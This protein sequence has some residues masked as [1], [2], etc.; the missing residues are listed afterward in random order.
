MASERWNRKRKQA[1][2]HY[3]GT[4]MACGATGVPLDIH[5][6]RYDNLGA[7]RMRDLV[8]LCR[9]C[10]EYATERWK[11]RREA[12][13]AP[14]TAPERYEKGYEKG[15][16]QVQ[17]GT[18]FRRESMVSMPSRPSGHPFAERFHP[19]TRAGQTEATETTGPGSP[20]TDAETL[21]RACRGRDT[22]SLAVEALWSPT[23]APGGRERLIPTL[24]ASSISQ[25]TL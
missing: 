16:E 12:A 10:H 19:E 7:E 6:V 3:R 23:A 4:C 14:G 17:N 13:E 11:A 21:C 5:H 22:L 8:A 24:I 9:P 18:P 1:V 25:E 15:P 2:R 20:L